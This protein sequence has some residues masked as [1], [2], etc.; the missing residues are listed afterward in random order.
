MP[1][2]RLSLPPGLTDDETAFSEQAR[3]RDGSNV[4]F[5]RGRP[6]VI[7]GWER[8]ANSDLIGV[9]RAILPWTD[10]SGLMNTAFGT[11]SALMIEQSGLLYDVTPFGLAAGSIDGLSGLG[12]GVGGYGGGG[13]GSPGSAALAPRTWSLANWGQNLLASP[14]G[15]TIYAWDNGDTTV[16]ATVATRA[17]LN[18]VTRSGLEVVSRPL[19][20][21][22]PVANAPAAVTCMIVVP[23]RQVIALGTNESVS[24]VFNPLC[25]RW[26]DLENRTVWGESP[27]NN[28]GE[29]ILEGSGQIVGAHVAPFGFFV[30]TDN[31]V[32][33]ARFVGDPGQTWRFDRLGQNAGLIGPKAVTV[34]GGVAVW[35]TP[36]GQFMRCEAGGAPTAIECPIL[37]DFWDNISPAQADKIQASAVSQ[38]NEIWWLYPDVRDGL[39]CSRYLA[40]SLVDGSWFR[41][42][43][44]RTAMVDNGVTPFP[45]AADAAGRVYYHEKG[46]SADG[47]SLSWSVET[48]DL[49]TSP[50]ADR[51]GVVRGVWPD[52]ERQGGPI[53]LTI[54]SRMRPQ[55][56]ET[57]KGSWSLPP[58][59]GRRDFMTSGRSVRL[60]FD[61]GGTASF[62]RFGVP[63]LDVQASG[64][65]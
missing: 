16:T 10:T 62:A 44:A 30:W 46:Q 13:Y 29:F 18:V 1:K 9:C 15:G 22:A 42:D 28:A 63:V 24:G 57:V 45:L 33:Y 4:R 40:L 6:E 23:E 53:T 3:W 47:G 60:R 48:S 56:T 8:F 7:G 26:S 52:F 2:I 49:V 54:L 25:I 64:K 38:Y 65:E 51:V 11:H 36:S 12:Y 35:L 27:T 39:E 41:G 50:E 61:G 5:W 14:R 37:R 59:L 43:L 55:G 32:F 58:G 17:S 34:V 20:I 31:A 19:A 21:A